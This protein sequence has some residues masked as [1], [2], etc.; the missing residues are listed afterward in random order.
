MLISQTGR[1]APTAWLSKQTSVLQFKLQCGQ[2][3]WP[4]RS[5]PGF[6]FPLPDLCVYVRVYVCVHVCMCYREVHC[7]AL[8]AKPVKNIQC[9][10]SHH[11]SMD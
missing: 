9:G 5:S 2:R 3:R 10:S 11:D 7:S 8:K 1:A 6:G 4:L